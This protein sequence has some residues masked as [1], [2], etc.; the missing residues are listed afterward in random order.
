VTRLFFVRGIEGTTY[1]VIGSIL[2]IVI[3]YLAIQILKKLFDKNSEIDPVER[4][5]QWIS[6]I[7][8]SSKYS[9]SFLK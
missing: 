4:E 9:F 6:T 8:R 7:R 5:N 2:W 1:G 3:K